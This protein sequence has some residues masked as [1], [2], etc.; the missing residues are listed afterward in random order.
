ML[1]GNLTGCQQKLLTWFLS[2][3][4]ESSVG[5]KKHSHSPSTPGNLQGLEQA[6]RPGKKPTELGEERIHQL[7]PAREEQK[8][9]I[10]DQD[11]RSLSSD[12]NFLRRKFPPRGTNAADK[13]TLHLCRWLTRP[14]GSARLL[15]L[16][17]SHSF[18]LLV[19]VSATWELYPIPRDAF[20]SLELSSQHRP[21]QC[22]NH[23]IKGA[24]NGWTAN[25][26]GSFQL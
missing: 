2:K 18:Q 12:L 14:G 21:Y 3:S 23:K 17:H 7:P 15:C 25:F 13:K 1:V 26:P 24:L 9:I 10:W 8:W 20:F 6:Q 11:S 5:R 4:L 16:S 19:I 22:L